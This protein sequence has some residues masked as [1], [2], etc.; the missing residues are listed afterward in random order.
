MRAVRLSH[1][2]RNAAHKRIAADRHL[3][4]PLMVCSE[5]KDVRACS[6]KRKVAFGDV[7]EVQHYL[8]CSQSV[9]AVVSVHAFTAYFHC[10]LRPAFPQTGCAQPASHRG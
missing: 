9:N 8:I 10:I 3:S 4:S 5:V 1:L 7:P 6:A 2:Y